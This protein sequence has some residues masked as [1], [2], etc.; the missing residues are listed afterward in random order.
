MDVELERTLDFVTS[1]NIQVGTYI[2]RRL[3]SETTLRCPDC[4]HVAILQLS[5]YIS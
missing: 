5:D 4:F 2:L 3:T 1:M